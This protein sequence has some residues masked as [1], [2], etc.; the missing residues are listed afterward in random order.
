MGGGIQKQKLTDD[1]LRQHM[2]SNSHLLPLPHPVEL[3]GK[4]VSVNC[5]KYSVDCVPVGGPTQCTKEKCLYMK[6]NFICLIH[7]IGITFI[8]LIYSMPLR[9]K[10]FRAIA[11]LASKMLVSKNIIYKIIVSPRE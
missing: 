9:I 2:G 3:A 10:K 1:C 4:L 8:I 11:N 7:E 6:R 5:F